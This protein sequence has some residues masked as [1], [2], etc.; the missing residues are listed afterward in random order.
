M[1]VASVAI[2]HGTMNAMIAAIDDQKGVHQQRGMKGIIL[3]PTWSP[4]KWC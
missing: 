2:A 1:I 4:P 3:V